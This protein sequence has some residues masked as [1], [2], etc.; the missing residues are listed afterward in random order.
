M[1]SV[2]SS[3]TAVRDSRAFSVYHLCGSYFCIHINKYTR[4]QHLDPVT[5]ASPCIKSETHNMISGDDK[6]VH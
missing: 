4:G 1:I 2:I 3:K 6:S 5:Y